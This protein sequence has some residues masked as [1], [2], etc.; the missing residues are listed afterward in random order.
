MFLQVIALV[1]DSF[2]DTDIFSDLQEA[3]RK[4]KIPVYIL[5]DQDF[6]PHFMEMCRNLG[7]C[8]EQEDVSTRR[9]FYGKL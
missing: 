9:V 5:L 3:Y 8:P 6:L 4:R 1:M 7:V 2:T